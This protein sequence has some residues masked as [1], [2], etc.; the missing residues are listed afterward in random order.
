[1][2]KNKEIRRGIVF[3]LTVFLSGTLYA[4]PVVSNIPHGI[5]TIN[6]TP[7]NT[8]VNQTS[9]KAIINWNS[10][11]IGANES[12]HFA[13]PNGGITLN[14][15]SPMQGASQ[16]YG[17]LTATGQIIL[18]NPA[19][20]HF[21]PSAYVNVGGLI[22]T[23]SNITDE[24]FLSG[25][26]QFDKVNG[27]NGAIINQ[28]TI[29][30]RDHGL[31]ALVG[32]NVTNEGHVQ[33]NLG[34]VVLASGEAFT[35]S[36]AGNDLIHF[37]VTKGSSKNGSGVRNTGSLIA[38][39]GTIMVSAKAAQN[40]LD[41]V[42]NMDGVA[43]ARSVGEV[44]GE[45]IISGDPN[46]TFVQLAGKVDASGKGAKEQGGDITIT[47]KN[48]LLSENTSVDV[49]GDFGG[50]NIWIGGNYQG[51]GPLPNAKAVVIA[52]NTLLAANAITKGNG[53]NIIVWSDNVTKTFGNI[54]AK[55]GALGGDGGFVETS[56]KGYLNAHGTKVN[57]LA[58]K[59]R[60]G[61][62]LLDP[63]NIVISTDPTSTGSFGGGDPNTF[64]PS[65]DDSVLNVGDLT[66]A[67]ASANVI[68]DTTSGSAQAGDITVN[69]AINWAQATSLT[70]SADNN[71]IVNAAING[72][73]A[74]SS[75]ISDAAN[76]TTINGVA[77]TAGTVQFNSD[78]LIADGTTTLTAG[79]GGLQFLGGN[80]DAAIG[81]TNA[82][83]VLAT[84]GNSI[85]IPI[86]GATNELNTISTSGA[87][88]LQFPTANAIRTVGA[89]TWGNPI[90]IN[91]TT[92]FVSSSAGDITFSAIDA[93]AT[94]EALVV[95]TSGAT[96]FNGLVGSS[97]PLL[98]ITTD[99]GGSTYFNTATIDTI[100]G[101]TYNDSIFLQ[102]NTTLT[103]ANTTITFNQIIE[104][105]S[106]L[107]AIFTV[108]AGNSINLNADIGG[109]IFNSPGLINFTAPTININTVIV[110]ALGAHTYDG[111]VIL[112]LDPITGTTT[113]FYSDLDSINFNSTV[114]SL[115]ATARGLIATYNSDVYFSGDVGA[116]NALASITAT[117]ID[118]G[119]SVHFDGASTIRTSGDQLYQ[120]D[121]V[122]ANDVVLISTGG[123]ITITQSPDATFNGNVSGLFN[124][125]IN[126]AGANSQLTGNLAMG[127]LTKAGTGTLIVSGTNTYDGL[128]AINDGTL[129]AD[130]ATALGSTASGTTVANGATLTLNNVTITEP[131]TLEGGSVLIGNATSTLNAPITLTPS[132][133]GAVSL[134]GGAG[135]T[136]TITGDIN[137]LVSLLYNQI[138]LGGTLVLAG[139]VGNTT[140]V[141]SITNSGGTVF[142]SSSSPMTMTSVNSQLHSGN[143]TLAGDVSLTSNA[144]E[145]LISTNFD[146]AH[147]LTLQ[148]ANGTVFS[149]SILGS[150]TPL[151]SLTVNDSA[152]I[153]NPTVITT[154]GNQAFNGALGIGGDLT[155]ISNAGN[156][157]LNELNQEGFGASNVV[158][159]G[160]NITFNDSVTL[161]EPSTINATAANNIFIN[162][163][164][165]LTGGN[166]TYN[167]TNL[168]LGTNGSFTAPNLTFN[169]AINADS[170]A[171]NRTLELDYTGFLSFNGNIGDSAALGE[172]VTALGATGVQFN[173]ATLVQTTGNQTYNDAV[174][175]D[176]NA[177][178]FVS[179]GGNIVFNDDVA[180]NNTLTINNAGAGSSVQ[181]VISGG[182]N[183][184]KAGTGTLRLLN[185]NDIAITT[186]NAG[187]LAVAAA[188]AL[189]AAPN[190]SVNNATF[191]IDNVSM[192][193]TAV[194]LNNAFLTGNGTAS[195]TG[196]ISPAVGSSNTIS[197]TGGSTLTVNANING[198]G[199][200]TLQGPG[201]VIING[202][203]GNTTP[204]TNF[205]A[206]ANATVNGSVTTSGNQT[207][208]GNLT[209]TADRSYTSGGT[210][211]FGGTI[212]GN[213]NLILSGTNIIFGGSIGNVTPLNTLTI[214][215]NTNFS[216]SSITTLGSQIF[217]SNLALG[218]NT[219]FNILG[220]NTSNDY[221]FS[222]ANGLTGGQN[223]Q[224]NA[225]NTND[226]YRFNVGGN[227]SV[228]NL[229]INGSNASANYLT[230]NSLNGLQSFNV[231][232][233]NGG[234]FATT[235]LGSGSFTNIQHLIGGSANDTFSFLGG[236]LSGT[237]NG[238][239][240]SNTI[241]GDNIDNQFMITSNNAGTVTSLGG[242]FANIQNLTG[243]TENNTFTFA[244]NARLSGNVDGR[245]LNK[246]NTINYEA[247]NTPITVA[248]SS[249]NDGTS[250]NQDTNINGFTNITHLEMNPTVNN[251]LVLP[252]K[253]NTLVITEA[254]NGY[255]N[256]PIFFTGFTTFDSISGTDTVI[257]NQ[258]PTY[259]SGS[260]VINGVT[261]FFSN[262]GFTIPDEVT[263]TPS[264][265]VSS[266]IQQPETNSDDGADSA[267]SKEPAW[268]SLNREVS[269]NIDQLLD[270]ASKDFENEL[271]K[272]K[273]N[274]FCTTAI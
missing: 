15:I 167:A 195:M 243:G 124:L 264:I 59:G 108:N 247:W 72:S 58:P 64:S 148:A 249:T 210:L 150:T 130:S 106:G 35:M 120:D 223:V 75:F 125:T 222:F 21:G 187:T 229:A 62:W 82:N 240:G 267:S 92:S 268:M 141:N 248:L 105:I 241:V 158:L 258:T 246:I 44:N 181:G 206:A 228:N 29:I 164:G 34:K 209:L 84:S 113:T 103:S 90:T 33:A 255:V 173:N 39:G 214:T 261:L 142:G 121:V 115:D 151:A 112:G 169:T 24:N 259:G 20:I 86:I 95:N 63:S 10:F 188:G 254:R 2:H 177:I 218:N 212:N 183:L 217:N 192:T 270:Q 245:T 118:G 9:Q 101:Q 7:G 91:D 70:L 186:V 138:G 230:F 128:T 231:T 13:Q 273:I 119:S 252:D 85:I 182:N 109:L 146:G 3:A 199:N 111:A 116:T 110:R 205:Q 38:N 200:L 69:A 139:N 274:P 165:I 152:R 81:A 135:G 211:T 226:T 162:T 40:V 126:N 175:I 26:Y 154:S 17:R 176:N 98:S 160:S 244:N 256:D 46:A 99:A 45:I 76:S 161:T 203:I 117:N 60:T 242:T 19:G 22:A 208:N 238:G 153:N 250:I 89:Q 50:G 37:N 239:A 185:N 207:Y 66:T 262:F 136:L 196:V 57:L 171:N 14:R 220:T 202:N 36:F 253:S 145:I 114:D 12:T 257:F 134:E 198:A 266:I 232:S 172:L 18:V 180:T 219:A 197:A 140:P 215:G 163:A 23:T 97:N 102:T 194:A 83:L 234:Q 32:N 65:G 52:P 184:I 144:G 68:V 166:Q 157:N 47:G 190:I 189:G 1:M 96:R 93:Q 6:Q 271:S 104:D 260:V 54:E 53:G 94:P 191:L 168:I 88:T 131:L 77:I 265:N 51:K 251:T 28:G 155:L 80:L 137:G 216:G 74:G 269:T 127:S 225:G 123:D 170:A 193:N 48:I 149:N 87:G 122:L 213:Q 147:N 235:G 227:I 56:S 221:S 5:V 42:I 201:A 237:I 67:L 132:G 263:T 4:N 61:T 55:G 233:A 25:V 79:A 71:V 224:L 78:V 43:Q 107:P 272:Y 8:V 11:N 159:S 178:Q 49:S 236:T 41:N 27:S 156:I 204:I 30:A 133:G 179:T 73:N 16:I 174:N 100:A 129:R 31:I 143:T